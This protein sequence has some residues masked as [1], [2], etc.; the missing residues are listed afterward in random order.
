MYDTAEQ[1]KKII[2]NDYRS[3]LFDKGNLN[4]VQTQK[5]NEVQLNFN[6]W[7]SLVSNNCMKFG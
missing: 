1:L 5:F 4:N 6:H 7:R 2:C 3:I